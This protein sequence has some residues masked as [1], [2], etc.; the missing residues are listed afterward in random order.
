MSIKFDSIDLNVAPYSISFSDHDTP[1]QNEVTVFNL[2]RERGSII[3]TNRFG[4]KELNITLRISGSSQTDLESKLDTFKELMG[5][6]AKNL[7][8]DYA[9]GV[10]RFVATPIF[11][12]I[13]KQYYNITFVEVDIKF[14][15]PNGIGTD[16]SATTATLATGN[17]ALTL[18][19]SFNIV[20][21]TEPK[22]SQIAMH[23]N[24]C[25]SIAQIH[26][27]VGAEKILLS[28]VF[29]AGD[30]ILFDF[31]NKKITVEGVIFDYA[32]FIPTLDVG[33]NNFTVTVIGTAINYDLSL[34]YNKT[35]L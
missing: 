31:E 7:D 28:K 35:Y 30:D 32:G 29:V 14:I 15:I 4:S 10:R 1:P 5:R 18:S 25:T 22:N 6:Q 23:I 34:S 11:P 8:V 2:S 26:L 24:S 19:S 17:T 27:Q 33:T 12:N 9:G 3:V 16:V 20:G 13:K 21:S